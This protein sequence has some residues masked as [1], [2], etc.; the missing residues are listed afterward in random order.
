MNINEVYNSLAGMVIEFR[1]ECRTRLEG[2]TKDRMTERKALQIELGMYS[3][4]LRAGLLCMTDT[5]E[6]KAEA[7]IKLRRN[8]CESIMIARFPYLNKL[9]ISLDGEKKK[10]F[11][12]VLQAEI[13]MRDQ[14][15][16]SYKEELKDAK[17]CGDEDRV[18]EFKIKVS[19]LER[20][21]GAWDKW[22]KENNLYP[23]IKWEV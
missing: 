19:A 10:I 21:F 8:I 22:R 18:F 5:N 16:R 20:V 6:E 13:F 14:I 7:V 1:D 2:V 15:F 17:A 11:L 3:L 9:Y 12:A 4:C 23:D